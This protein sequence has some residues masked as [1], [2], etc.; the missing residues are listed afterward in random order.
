LKTIRTIKKH[1][2]LFTKISDAKCYFN[3]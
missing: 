3:G 2:A 1:F